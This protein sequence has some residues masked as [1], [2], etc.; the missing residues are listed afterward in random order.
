MRDRYRSRDGHRRGGGAA[1]PRRRARRR[2]HL[3][4]E[5]HPLARPAEPDEI[6]AVISFLASG[7][8]GYVNG[9]ALPIDGVTTSIDPTAL[10]F[11]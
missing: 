11:G 1:P 4:H 9:V 10:A 6:A 7:D 3:A 2:P 8:A 5:G